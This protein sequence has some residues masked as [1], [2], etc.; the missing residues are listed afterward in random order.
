MKGRK[1]NKFRLS[2]R[3]YLLSLH[4]DLNNF[5][6]LPI[7]YVSVSSIILGNYIHNNHVYIM[8]I[9]IIKV[10][11]HILIYNKHMLNV[12]HDITLKRSFSE[13]TD[14]GL[15]FQ[16]YAFKKKCQRVFCHTLRQ[17]QC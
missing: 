12:E 1:G 17:K 10:Y 11:T 9:H 3:D 13:R 4:L 6:E 16:N 7:T 8:Y 2:F 15:Y 14:H 5:P